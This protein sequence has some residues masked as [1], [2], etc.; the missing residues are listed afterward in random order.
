MR[1]IER[2]AIA[3]PPGLYPLFRD[4]ARFHTHFRR[5][6]ART[7]SI[8]P[9]RADRC[10]PCGVFLQCPRPPFSFGD[11]PVL[12]YRLLTPGPTPVPEETLLELAKPVPHHR[13][14]EFRQILAEVL[15]D[16]QKVYVTKNPVLPL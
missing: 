13:T 2:V 6:S 4:R 8:P 5:K 14:A 7:P 9:R 12:K 3:L 15:Q 16:L 1:V 10:P 11:R